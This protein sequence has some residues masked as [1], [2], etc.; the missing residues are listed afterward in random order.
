VSQA[1]NSQTPPADALSRRT[2]LGALG[3]AAAALWLTGCEISTQPT[4]DLPD[5][6]TPLPKKTTLADRR[7]YAPPT[8]TREA[9][10]D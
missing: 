3:V 1:R 5:P 8:P 4:V 10:W 9:P 7:D 2:V 6:L